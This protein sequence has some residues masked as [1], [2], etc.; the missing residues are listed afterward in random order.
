[1]L[2]KLKSFIEKVNEHNQKCPRYMK[3]CAFILTAPM[4]LIG[5]FFV[6]VATFMKNIEISITAMMKYVFK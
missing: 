6:Q 4:I 3:C 2:D 1:M 5:M